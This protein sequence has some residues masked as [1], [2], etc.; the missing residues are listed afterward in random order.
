MSR[1]T[2]AVVRTQQAVL[3]AQIQLLQ[4]QESDL[5]THIDALQATKERIVQQRKALEVEKID[6]AAAVYPINWLPSELLIA[7]FLEFDAD[8]YILTRVCH[9]WRYLAVAT[10]ELWTRLLPEWD[11]HQRETA[12]RRTNGAL[13]DVY[14][15]DQ[16]ADIL[17]PL[18]GRMARIR[19]MD[20]VLRLSE[21]SSALARM[22]NT[23]GIPEMRELSLQHKLGFERRPPRI[24]LSAPSR[25]YVRPDK[26]PRLVSLKLVNFWLFSLSPY[27][28]GNLTTLSLSYPSRD[29]TIGPTLS[30][31]MLIPFFKWTPH[32]T[33]LALINTPVAIGANFQN[34]LP[35]ILPKL[36]TLRWNEPNDDMVHALLFRLLLPS[37]L[38]LDLYV[39]IPPPIVMYASSNT[40]P[41]RPNINALQTLTSLCLKVSNADTMSSFTRKF[42]YPVLQTLE[43]TCTDL[44]GEPLVLPKMESIF[45]DPR[46]P[47]LTHLVLTAFTLENVPAMLGYT[48]VLMS[49]SVDACSG[50]NGVFVA[51]GLGRCPRLEDLAFWAC[52]DLDGREVVKALRVRREGVVLGASGTPKS[53]R[54]VRKLRGTGTVVR[55]GKPMMIRT[56]EIEDC[57]KV[58]LEHIDMI[59]AMGVDVIYSASQ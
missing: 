15:D 50:A 8:P 1:P 12:I 38:L 6:A 4:S 16:G 9:K 54:R 47:H 53:D 24:P 40:N 20:I 45:R 39:Q 33:S 13:L 17:A 21:Y 10:P 59:V 44:R 36:V 48:P 3:A 58:S 56:L 30:L 49:L 19:S 23:S 42:D 52:V 55:E 41:P 43:L 34:T 37:I 2:R 28:F 25:E 57:G 11:Q 31:G 5:Q 27:L 29:T 51:L 35:V 22:I 32:L 46:Q 7:I 26:T 14:Y 18:R